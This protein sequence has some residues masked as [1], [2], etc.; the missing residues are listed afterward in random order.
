MPSP[1]NFNEVLSLIDETAK[2]HDEWRKAQGEERKLRHAL[3]KGRSIDYAMWEQ[4]LAAIRTARKDLDA[5]FEKTSASAE[6]NFHVGPHSRNGKIHGGLFTGGRTHW[7]PILG[8]EETFFKVERGKDSPIYLRFQKKET[9]KEVTLGQLLDD[10]RVV[11]SINALQL[12]AKARNPAILAST[13]EHESVHFDRMLSQDGMVGHAQNETA[14]YQRIID[15]AGDIGLDADHVADARSN[16]SSRLGDVNLQG[17]QSHFSGKPYRAQPG[18]KDYPYVPA[19]DSHLDGWSAYQGRLKAIEKDQNEL[20][21]RIAA[22]RS[23][24]DPWF[25]RDPPN[26]RRTP[27]PGASIHDGCSTPGFMAGDVYMPPMPCARILPQPPADVA[28]PAVPAP[29][30]ILIPVRASRPLLGLAGRI[31]ADPSA[32][33]SQ[34]FHD[35]YAFAWYDAT[36]D[37]SALPKCQREIYL[38]LVRIRQEG[39]PDFNS[40]YFQAM[41]ENLNL[42]QAPV[43]VPPA[44]EIDVPVRPGPATRDC[45][46]ADG[47]R[48]IR[49]R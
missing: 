2:Y 13:L 30:P 11:I 18:S 17:W 7:N 33:H 4:S 47:R 15:I 19:P 8:T 28:I 48:C 42:P 36:Q 46:L 35:E 3:K 6:K 34:P 21:L 26:A 44:P 14:A 1:E 49:W 39:S 40:A 24:A 38:V 32:A 27:P 45:V 31:C 22:V 20:A 5:S 29:R 16:V 41:A 43:F 10:G 23:G 25:L 37:V 12:A 9:A